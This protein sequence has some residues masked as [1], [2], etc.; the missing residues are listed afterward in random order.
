MLSKEDDHHH[1]HNISKEESSNNNYNN[2][3]EGRTTTTT[4]VSDVGNNTIR[5]NAQLT[6]KFVPTVEFEI[7]LLLYADQHQE[8]LKI[9]KITC[10]ASKFS[11]LLTEKSCDIMDLSKHIASHPDHV[12]DNHLIASPM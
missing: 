7:I 11:H 4:T 1:H 9:N 12:F 6:T 2:N 8:N 5:D 10:Q 3:K